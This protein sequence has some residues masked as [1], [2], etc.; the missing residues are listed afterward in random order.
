MYRTDILY[1]FIDKEIFICK[2]CIHYAGKLRC[3]KSVY[4]AFVGADMS[5][6]IYYEEGKICKHCGKPT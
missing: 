5:D 2:K 4:I 1:T 6:C 3:N